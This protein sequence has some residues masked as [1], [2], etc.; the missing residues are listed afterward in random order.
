MNTSYTINTALSKGVEIITRH[1]SPLTTEYISCQHIYKSYSEREN[2]GE[3]TEVADKRKRE[4][5]VL[6]YCLSKKQINPDFKKSISMAAHWTNI[7]GMENN[8]VSRGP[9]KQN[10]RSRHVSYR[11]ANATSCISKQ[12]I[13]SRTGALFCIYCS[14]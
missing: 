14:I 5:Q 3:E 10:Y 2:K 6:L 7:P 1:H 11:L 13:G 12:R 4:S 9:W 8:C